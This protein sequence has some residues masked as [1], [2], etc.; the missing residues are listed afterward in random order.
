MGDVVVVDVQPSISIGPD[1]SVYSGLKE[2]ALHCSDPSS[3]FLLKVVESIKRECKMGRASLL[4]DSMDKLFMVYQLRLKSLLQLLKNV[5]QL[6]PTLFPFV[7]HGDFSQVSER[8]AL[9]TEFE[10]LLKKQSNSIIRVEKQ[11]GSHLLVYVSAVKPGQRF[12]D[13]QSVVQITQQHGL[14][15]LGN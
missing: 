15:L 10:L 7:V 12:S 6:Q 1:S 5:A 9:A 2:D 11:V 13:E 14:R 3:S 4:I 8:G